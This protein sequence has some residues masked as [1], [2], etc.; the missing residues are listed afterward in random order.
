MIAAHEQREGE[1]R[2]GFRIGFVQADRPPR[3]NFSA[4]LH[5]ATGLQN[6]DL[7]ETH[8]TST[9]I[10]LEA[11]ELSGDADPIAGL[12]GAPSST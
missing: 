12:A 9:R 11:I 4:E 10:S 6:C 3:V 1:R 8:P 7:L 2:T 5:A